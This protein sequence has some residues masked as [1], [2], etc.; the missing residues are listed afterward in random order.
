MGCMGVEIYDP[1]D[2]PNI[3]ESNDSECSKYPSIEESLEAWNKEMGL[4]PIVTED[5]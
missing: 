3:I 2:N 4:A 5:E 1:L